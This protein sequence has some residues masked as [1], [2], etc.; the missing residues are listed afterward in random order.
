MLCRPT[1]MPRFVRRPTRRAPFYDR[2]ALRILRVSGA[3][4]ESDGLRHRV[5][6][7]DLPSPLPLPEQAREVAE[8]LK[9]SL[10]LEGRL[11]PWNESS[12][13]LKA[14][15]C[16][17]VLALDGPAYMITLCLG[18]AR[19]RRAHASPRGFLTHVTDEIR[20]RLRSVLDRDVEFWF[21]VEKPPTGAEHLHGV[22]GLAE[23]ELKR[24]ASALLHVAGDYY[25]P[26]AVRFQPLTGAL[27]AGGYAA[28]DIDF[29]QLIIPG[30]TFMRTRTLG[31]RA[32]QLYEFHRLVHRELIRLK[33]EAAL[34]DGMPGHA[35]HRE[36]RTSDHPDFGTW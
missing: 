23:H 35:V 32:E 29:T 5:I 14:P 10:V 25:R 28:K 21:I 13:A 15:Y 12:A 11:H 7:P 36:L 8:K 34:A 16:S 18:P 26:R 9:R 4:R 3:L 20:R 2:Q 1:T 30:P 31:Q 17:L 24:A 27:G 22:M 33:R 19:R 6:T